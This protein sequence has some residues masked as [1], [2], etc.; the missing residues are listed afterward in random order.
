LKVG[1]EWH[2]E[3]AN[4]LNATGR[5]MYLE[6]VAGYW[7]LRH[8]T[9]Q[10]SNAWR[11]CTDHHDEWQ[12]TVEAISCRIDEGARPFNLT[13]GEAGAW[14]YNDFLMT[15]G[16]GCAPYEEG[17]S[18]MHCP[19]QTDDQYVTEFSLWS[20]TQSPLVVST[21]VRNMTGVMKRALL[22]SELV[23]AHQSTATPPG[24]LRAANKLGGP[25]HE[26]LC[27]GCQVWARD[28]SLAPSAG[29]DPAPSVLVALVNWEAE[30]A[31][32]VAATWAMLGLPEGQAVTVRDLWTH[33]DWP[34]VFGAD[35]SSITAQAVPPSGTV[36]LQLTPVSA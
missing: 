32:D 6:I 35:S 24:T 22:N 33:E 30:G 21:D 4:A 2:K 28:L 34:G 12:S 25:D 26:S 10:Y 13:R 16:N 15:G 5:P 23:N 17:V 36:V 11:F 14:P 3:F 29:S 8:E 19:G 31:K 7:F 1:A 20:L 9:A 18:G 27:S